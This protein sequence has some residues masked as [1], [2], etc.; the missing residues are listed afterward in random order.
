MNKII[1][2]VGHGKTGS[3]Y[4]QS[5]LALNSK[6]LSSNGIFY[7]YHSSFK[8]AKTGEVSSGNG[9]ILVQNHSHI[10]T[11]CK[12]ENTLFSNENFYFNLH[13][14]N[15]EWFYKLAK[16]LSGRLKV[17]LFTRNYFELYFSLWAQNVKRGG[18][19][20]DIDTFLKENEVDF[21]AYLQQWINISKQ[22]NFELK[23]LNYSNYKKNLWMKFLEE[24]LVDC[25]DQ[26]I[27]SYTT[28]DQTIINRSLS[29]SEYEIQRICN[30]LSIEN[31]PLSDLL[32]NK[33]PDIKPMKIKCK[34]STYNE[35][36]DK[37]YKTIGI[38]NKHL[39]STE[40]IQ[41]EDIDSV[42]YP[43]DESNFTSL[44]I[45][46]IDIISEYLSVESHKNRKSRLKSPD[47]D[48][49]MQLRD[50][51]L[52]I[53]NNKETTL[54]DALHLMAIAQSIIPESEFISNTIENWK[55]ALQRMQITSQK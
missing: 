9:S 35:I 2:H 25:D 18:M 12:G 1:L 30:T 17:I 29:S 32:V 11:I 55:I 44:S 43:N 16:G 39:S 53:G 20:K 33:L 50:I 38:I 34:R 31:P 37:N 54:K 5:C 23:V 48:S 46:Q 36:K 19:T 15:K 51:A 49:A 24:L 22:Y 40:C 8:T 21:Y 26:G 13:T 6:Q 42:T 14:T 7:P 4:L 27:R 47:R 52:K 45:E 41:I 3:S 28:P 10:N